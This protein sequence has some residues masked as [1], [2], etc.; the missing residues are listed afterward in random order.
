M[1]KVQISNV[2]TLSTQDKIG[3]SMRRSIPLLPAEAG[4]QVMAMLTPT[5]LAVAAGTLIAWGVSH[6]FGVGEICDAILLVVGLASMGWGF[7]TGAEELGK[8]AM[9]AIN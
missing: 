7:F 8:F 2:A 3:E 1:G 9:T 6:F 5:A 4:Q